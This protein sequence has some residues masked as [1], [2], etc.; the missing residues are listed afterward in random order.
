VLRTY[1]EM[2]DE[3][4]KSLCDLYL[5]ENPEMR[6]PDAVSDNC[7][8]IS[9]EFACFLE[10]HG[11]PIEATEEGWPVIEFRMDRLRPVPHIYPEE[12][13]CKHFVLAVGD[14]AVDWTARQFGKDMPVPLVWPLA[15]A[16]PAV[17]KNSLGN[18]MHVRNPD[19]SGDV[20]L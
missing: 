3:Q 8:E 12:T 19:W 2:M 4:L 15:A 6:D 11:W 5:Q 17:R 10:S 18:T 16:K 14:L 20:G 1:K 13:Q 7:L 9:C